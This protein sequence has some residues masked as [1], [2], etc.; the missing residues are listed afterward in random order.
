MNQVWEFFQKLFDT[1]DF[2][3]RWHCGRWSEFHGWLYI[4]SDLSIWAAYFAIPII[5]I[6]Y[7]SRRYDARFIRVYFLFASFILACG[8]TH[9]LDA[10]MFW[11]PYYR[12]NA[13]M[14]LAT[15]IVSWM[16]VFSL[17]KLLP[18]A[19]T[20]KTPEELEKE[21]EHRKRVEEELLVN[22]AML[23]EAQEIARLGHWQW[24]VGSDKVKW[25]AMTYKLFGIEPDGEYMA[26][27]E[28]LKKMHPEDSPFVQ[29]VISK[30]MAEKTFPNFYHRVILPD[31]RI[32]TMLSRGEVILDGNGEVIRL[33]GT[34]QDVTEQ[35]NIEQELLLK[36][37]KLEATNAELQK[38][39]SIASHDLREP[40]RKII[41]FGSMLE[42]NYEEALGEKGTTYLQKITN[43]S[44][45]MQKLIDDILDFS[46]L[47]V[48]LQ[49]FTKVNLNDV[50]NNILSDMEVAIEK[51]GTQIIVDP[52]P[53]ID[54]IDSLIGQLFQN[55]I[56]NAIKFRRK[57]VKPVIKIKAEIITRAYFTP[58][59]ADAH[60]TFTTGAN[61]NDN[62][63]FCKILISDNGIG[64]DEAYLDRIFLIFQR[65]HAKSEYEGTGIGLA[66]VKKVVDF[67]NGFITASSKPGEG[68]TFVVIL[69]VEQKTGD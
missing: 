66:I 49:S 35:K 28:Y 58:A 22:N 27:E 8:A 62:E 65:L 19:F 60:K 3:P 56:G 24:E 61:I 6:K 11:Y 33:I 48:N 63:R 47:T 25:S 30:V 45:R 18:V 37:Q 5:I 53:E 64:F 10:I 55:M 36:S 17:I 16:T 34:M 46:K 42:K 9:L 43:A 4:I 26:Y 7:I 39:A 59:E 40:L 20:L 57:D 69:P 52:L 2:P 68:T 51:S 32:R 1:S 29:E 14:R 12:V 23:Q 38:F 50:V 15:G 41:T 44:S 54:A 31:G 13:L 67:H 21:I